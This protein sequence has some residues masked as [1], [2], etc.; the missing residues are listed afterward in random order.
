M[1]NKQGDNAKNSLIFACPKKLQIINHSS[2]S[3]YYA[4]ISDDFSDELCKSGQFIQWTPLMAQKM[5]KKLAQ[6]ERNLKF[7]QK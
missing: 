6:I 5:K 3:V 4:L 2:L 7:S 1:F